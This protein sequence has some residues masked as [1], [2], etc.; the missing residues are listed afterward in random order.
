MTYNGTCCY[1]TQHLVYTVKIHANKFL[2]AYW[3]S[4]QC[5]LLKV[6]KIYCIFT[7]CYVRQHMMT[8][9]DLI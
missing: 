1:G 9:L 8:D 5:V 3:T 2:D 4:K 6:D 7:L